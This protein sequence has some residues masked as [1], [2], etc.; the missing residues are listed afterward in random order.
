MEFSLQNKGLVPIFKKSR[1]VL[2]DRLFNQS[3]SKKTQSRWYSEKLAQRLFLFLERYLGLNVS[4]SQSQN[5]TRTLKTRSIW[6]LKKYQHKSSFSFFIV[7][8]KGNQKSETFSAFV[9]I[10]EFF[11]R[12]LLRDETFREIIAPILIAALQSN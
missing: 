9:V 11:C 3:G 7:E 6:H 10:A 5:E 1:V 8:N 12:N 2:L 4:T